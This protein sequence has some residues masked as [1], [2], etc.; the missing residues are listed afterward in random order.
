MGEWNLSGD[1]LTSRKMKS[2]LLIYL[3]QNPSLYEEIKDKVGDVYGLDGEQEG[4]VAD[5]DAED[6]DG[7]GEDDHTEVPLRAVIQA[8][9]QLDIPSA[10]DKNNYCVSYEEVVT[11]EDGDLRGGGEAEDV[12][13]YRDDGLSWADAMASA[14]DQDLE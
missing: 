5:E 3:E 11:E 14:A 6:K 9:L 7:V 12:W 8:T 4:E 1:M 2:D 10:D 13:A